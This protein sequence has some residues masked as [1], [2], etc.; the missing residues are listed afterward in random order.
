MKKIIS[1]SLVLLMLATLLMTATSCG[2]ESITGYTRLRD[3]IIDKVGYD[4]DLPLDDA[5]EKEPV[6]LT[7]VVLR[8]ATLEGVDD[9]ERVEFI[10]SYKA[11]SYELRVTVQLNG[12]VEKA[13]LI[14]E[15]LQAEQDSATGAI[16]WN[17]YASARA[18]ILLTHY[19]GNETVAFTSMD[20]IPVGGEMSERENVTAILNSVLKVVDT[21]L[22]PALDMD[23]HDLGFIVLSEKYM[24][25]KENIEIEEDLG[26]AFSPA[27]LKMAGL[28]IL[29]GEGMVF[30][31]LAILW[32]VL[33]IFKSVFYKDP[34]K[35][36]KKDEPK[37]EKAAK[38]NSKA[39]PA[40]IPTVT[41]PA[42]DDGQLIA[43]IT[44]AVASTIESD[45]ALTSQF[46]SGFRVVSFKKTDKSRNR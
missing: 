40:P 12:S 24:A 29:M 16:T 37:P 18:D 30:L 19:T 23:L 2:M 38:D 42:A 3:H 9:T 10:G 11:A 35:A 8:V 36:A 26:G 33:L 15:I 21:Y 31:V 39:T 32:I 45:P 46:A 17:V 20:V 44:A 7:S 1:L 5:L 41:A 34:A 25:D 22:T 14:Y 6:G 28:I 13:K 27:R 4:K 43:V